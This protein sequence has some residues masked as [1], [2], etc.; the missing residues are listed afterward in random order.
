MLL[1]AFTLKLTSSISVII[2][3]RGG[4]AFAEQTHT[5]SL[6]LYFT[7]FRSRFGFRFTRA[8]VAILTMTLTTVVRRASVR[9]SSLNLH[10]AG[11]RSRLRFRFTRAVVAI[12]TVTLAPVVRT[13]VR[14]SSLNLHFTGFGSRFRFRFSRA[15]VAIL[16][17]SFA[18]MGVR[19]TMRM[20]SLNRGFCSSLFG[21]GIANMTGNVVL[22]SL[23]TPVSS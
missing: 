6:N 7:G 19:A 3:L 16:T 20:P 10:F 21:N 12:L 5:S 15:V 13:A 1:V 17:M 14:M 4:F 18:T 9:V 2:W 23:P 22:C 8:V 11:F